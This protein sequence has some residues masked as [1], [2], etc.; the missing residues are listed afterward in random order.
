MDNSDAAG[1]IADKRTIDK[2]RELKLNLGSYLENFR[3]YE[4]FE[5]T[6]DLIFTGPTGA[7]VSDLYI[8]LNEHE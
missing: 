6:G 3:A 2:S 4:V 1:V 5:A 7:N 8:L